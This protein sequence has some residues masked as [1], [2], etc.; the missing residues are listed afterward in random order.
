MLGVQPPWWDLAPASLTPG[1]GV[2]VFLEDPDSTPPVLAFKLQSQAIPIERGSCSTE[3]GA[4]ATLCQPRKSHI[5]YLRVVLRL[6]ERQ[7]VTVYCWFRPVY[8]TMVCCNRPHNEI[9]S[10]LWER[11]PASYPHAVWISHPR[12]LQRLGLHGYPRP[13]CA[14]LARHQVRL[15]DVRHKAIP[16]KEA[17]HHVHQVLQTIRVSGSNHAV[18]GIE[19]LQVPPNCL[20]QPIMSHPLVLHCHDH[21]CSDDSNHLY[22]FVWN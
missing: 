17:N 6:T 1:E 9:N 20:Y 8:A 2:W 18:I 12:A 16:P 13:Q 14:G 3:K 11:D 5:L 10:I 15:G 4:G 19:N 21:T 7:P 22:S